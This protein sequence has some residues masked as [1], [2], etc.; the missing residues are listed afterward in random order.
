MTD[1][2]RMVSVPAHLVEV[3]IGAE[4]DDW[5]NSYALH[6]CRICD[7]YWNEHPT[8]PR[9]E[10]HESWCPVPELRRLLSS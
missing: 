5:S 9:A 3:V 8:Q 7:G 6:N 10:N 1:P 4:T 2:T